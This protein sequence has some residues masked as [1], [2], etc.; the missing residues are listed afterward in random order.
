MQRLYLSFILFI[1]FALGVLAQHDSIPSQK[2][3]EVQVVTDAQPSSFKSATLLQVQ[4]IDKIDKLGVQSVSDAVRRFAGVNVKDYGGIGG[5]KTVSIRGLG[6]QHTAVSYDGVTV[7]EAQSGQVD[8]G[9][10]SLDNI[11]FMSM[12]I[13][14]PDDIFNSARHFASAGVLSINT[15]KP[16]FDNRKYKGRLTLRSGS[17]GMFNPSLVYAFKLSSSWAATAN[18]GWQRADGT[19]KFMFNNGASE[20]KRKRYNSD[21]DI[22]NTELNVYGD[23]KKAGS[24]KFKVNYFD[25]ERGLPILTKSNYEYAGERLWD[26][27]IFGQANYENKINNTFSVQGLAKYTRDYNRYFNETINLGTEGKGS[28]TDKYTQDEYYVSATLLYSPIKVLSFS[29]AQDYFHNNLAIDSYTNNNE[30]HVDK[31]AN[32]NTY[33]TSANFKLNTN[34]LTVIGGVLATYVGGNQSE[35]NNPDDLKRLSPS[36][37]LSYKPFAYDLRLRASYKDVFR[38]PSFNDVYYTQ[39]GSRALKPEKSKQYNL[40][41]VWMSGSKSYLNYVSISVDGYINKVQDKIV[42]LTSSSSLYYI[43]MIN[44]GEITIKGVDLAATTDITLA[45]KMSLNLTGTYSYQHAKDNKTK[46]VPSYTPEHSGNMSVSF[47]NPWLNV[48][49]SFVASGKRYSTTSPESRYR[50]DSFVDHSVSVN[51]SFRVNTISSLRLQ[52]ELLNLADKNYEII[53]GYPMPG[54]SFRVSATLMF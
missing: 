17:F 3:D 24:L 38:V 8:I 29:L 19:Y 4:S 43:G 34:K 39:V 1:A 5:L 35:G 12:S 46:T 41:A 18:V 37:S 33:L 10:F 16:T 44:M 36:L 23:L 32:R 15:Q 13:G 20:E 31:W 11:S 26:K 28:R 50:V 22:W 27:N 42:M 7:T 40:G 25:S 2:I 14:Q 21:V 48:S 30:I 47:E 52:A 49:Y 45:K 53:K 9:R 51:K 54:R 6:A